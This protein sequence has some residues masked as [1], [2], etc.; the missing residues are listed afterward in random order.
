MIVHTSMHDAALVRLNSQ[1]I[2]IKLLLQLSAIAQVDMAANNGK[3]ARF[4]MLRSVHILKNNIHQRS[5]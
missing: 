2:V 3:I 4:M 5:Y 1:Q